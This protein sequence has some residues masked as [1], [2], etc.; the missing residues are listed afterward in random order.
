MHWKAYRRRV[1][2][3]ILYAADCPN[4]P[5]ARSRV[6]EAL[7]AARVHAVV[8]EFEVGSLEEAERLGLRGSPTI[9][10]DGVDPFAGGGE[11]SI[12]CR[13]YRSEGRPRGSPSVDDLVAVLSP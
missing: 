2:I 4:L 13:L 9:K 8:E 11:V 3:E 5:V 1:R 6:H 7:R 12:S 10:V